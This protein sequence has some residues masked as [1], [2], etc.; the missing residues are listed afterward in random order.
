MSEDQTP[1]FALPVLHIG[2]AAKEQT[3]NEALALIDLALCAVV[4]D[5]GVD[6]PPEEPQPGQC[7]V[8]GDAPTGVWAGNARAIAGWTDGGWRFVAAHTGLSAWCRALGVQVTFHDH[9]ARG[10]MHAERI[11]IGGEQVVGSR[12]PAIEAPSGGSVVDSEARAAITTVIAALRTH[13]L[14]E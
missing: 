6:V 12:Q 13:G 3:H 2:Q 10:V 1:R 9:W 4:E 14:I 7:W 5:V 11:L 8:V